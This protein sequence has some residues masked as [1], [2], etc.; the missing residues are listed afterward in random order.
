MVWIGPTLVNMMFSAG[1]AHRIGK[2]EGTEGLGRRRTW[3]LYTKLAKSP[4]SR[5]G[6]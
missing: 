3:G 4:V 6:S 1:W 2:K 5:I